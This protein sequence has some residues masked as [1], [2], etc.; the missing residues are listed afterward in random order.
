MEENR[1]WLPYGSSSLAFQIDSNWKV[2]LID[3]QPVEAVSEP[4]NDVRRALQCPIGSAP[5]ASLL[6]SCRSAAIAINDKTRPVP[7]QFLLP[8]LLAELEGLGLL[9][10]Q[11]KLIIAT[12]THPPMQPDEFSK[13]LPAE[14]LASYQVYS[15]DA[16]DWDNL[17][18]LGNTTR[19]TPIWINKTFIQ[20]DLRIVVGN[21]EPHQFQGFSGGVKSAAIGLAGHTTIDKNHAWMTDANAD[22]GI[23]EENPARQD[24]EEIGERL[25]VHFALNAILNDHKEIVQVLAG[26]PRQVIETG[27]PLATRI[28]QVEVNKLYD[29]VIASAG[30][31]PKDI[32]VYQAQKALAHACRIAKPGATVILIA[33][34]P[35]GSGSQ[36]YENWV[37][38]L[39][40]HQSVIERFRQEGFR[41]GPHKAFLIARDSLRTHVLFK[42]EMQPSSAQKLLLEPVDDLN[43]VISTVLAGL[44]PTA[45]IA[46]LPRATSTIPRYKS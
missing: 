17:V 45:S 38:A 37:Q 42:S 27:I 36:G 35:E 21:I 13:V 33:A 26:H 3:L 7:H 12:G 32:N 1:F 24:V 16:D 46:I 41:V 43:H 31:H 5:L 9:P 30:G 18:Y 34:C 20:A 6:S 15:H 10:A 4:L 28:C 8:P 23:Y 40:D 29:M 11:I 25:G 22:I 19:G 44:P 39:P 14:I 2:D